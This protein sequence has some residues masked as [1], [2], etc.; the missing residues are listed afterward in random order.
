METLRVVETV[1]QIDDVTPQCQT[2]LDERGGATLKRSGGV[3]D[4]VA[5][6]ERSPNRRGIFS[7]DQEIGAR[8]PRRDER[9][10]AV[11]LEPFRGGGAEP[12]APAKDDDSGHALA[13]DCGV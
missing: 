9:T 10:D 1:R 4:H 12:S 6:T 8:P 2:R 13:L 5:F 3:D 7:I 11:A